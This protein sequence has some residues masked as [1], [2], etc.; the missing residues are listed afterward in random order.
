MAVYETITLTPKQSNIFCWGFQPEARHRVAVCGR[1]F[2]KTFLCMREVKRAAQLAAKRGIH[3]DNEIWY[4]CPSLKQAKRVFWP[5]LKRTI[6]VSWLEGKPNETECSIRLK[7]GHTIRIVG[8]DNYD[9]LR[10]SGLFFFIGDEWADA[11]HQCWDEVIAPMLATCLGHSLLIGT[12]KGFDHFYDAFQKGQEGTSSR[13]GYK[14]WHYTTAQGGNV[15]QREIDDARRDRDAR[16][17]EQEYEAGFLT[18]SG[19]V[20]YAFVRGDSVKP[21]PH[22][23]RLP[24]HI[25]MDFN[26]NPMSATV[27]QEVGDVSYQ[28]G[29][30]M[31]P[32]SNTDEMCAEI[33]RRYGRGGN[34]QHITVYPDPAGAQRR[35][36]AQGKTDIS[37]LRDAGFQVNAL[38]SHPLVRD[39]INMTN[40]RF[41][42]ATGERRA[43]V[44]PTCKQSITAYE[45]LTYKDGTGDPDKDSGFDHPVDATGYYM[46]TRFGRNGVTRVK[47]LY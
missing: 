29:E 37:I 11:K 36:S 19:R 43:F 3:V 35:T 33:K 27:W 32:T 17:F 38:S 41:C 9:N 39:R 4:G 40:A 23:P 25:G 8:L 7:S 13:P 5:R 15:A 10:G 26:V 42:N 14:S 1:R 6:P 22:D 18:Y 16:S 45:R 21:C 2:G 31:I 28:V 24:L 30:I 46:F 44:D 34:V 20:L 47:V 12:P